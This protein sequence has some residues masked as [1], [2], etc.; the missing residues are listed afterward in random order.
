MCWNGIH[1]GHNISSLPHS[2]H[3]ENHLNDRRILLYFFENLFLLS[4][5]LSLQYLNI[6][7]QSLS[8][9][10]KTIFF[11]LFHL[12]LTILGIASRIVAENRKVCVSSMFTLHKMDI[13]FPRYGIRWLTTKYWKIKRIFSF[14]WL[15]NVMLTDIYFSC[16]VVGN[17]NFF[18]LF[19]FFFC[20]CVQLFTPCTTTDD[21]FVVRSLFSITKWW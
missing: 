8:I 3:S 11:F 4:F 16:L 7:T 14:C 9:T 12:I 18:F 19:L 1:F 13:F 2:R 10:F 20:M 21:T 17:N 5:L 15:T 6:W